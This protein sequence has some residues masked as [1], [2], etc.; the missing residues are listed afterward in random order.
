MSL[1][2]F[3]HFYC[4]IKK[5]WLFWKGNM[6][7]YNCRCEHV[8]MRKNKK[9]QTKVLWQL[10]RHAQKHTFTNR[11]HFS[12]FLALSLAFIFF[13]SSQIYFTTHTH[14]HC[15]AE[16]LNLALGSDGKA[17]P[18]R[19]RHPGSVWTG[20]RSID[21]SIKPLSVIVLFPIAQYCCCFLRSLS[22]FFS[23]PINVQMHKYIHHNKPDTVNDIGMRLCQL[24]YI[25]R[26]TVDFGDCV[27]VCVSL[28]LGLL[29]ICQCS[30]AGLQ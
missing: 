27:C 26:K 22:L 17:G 13:Y 6:V 11:L 9:K 24:S 29:S 15:R 25:F 4:R 18:R 1:R 2:S 8:S 30:A 10:L 21:Q 19:Q 3:K 12:R 28:S 7:K 20:K 14:A 16:L 5:I 23:L